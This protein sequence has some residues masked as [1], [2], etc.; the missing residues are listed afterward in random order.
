VRTLRARYPQKNP[1]TSTSRRGWRQIRWDTIAAI[2]SAIGAL[3]S[4]AVAVYTLHI[5]IYQQNI[6]RDAVKATYQSNLYSK[7]VDQYANFRVAY[8][9]VESSMMGIVLL[10]HLPS[11]GEPLS[12]EEVLD[13]QGRVKE[14]KEDMRNFLSAASRL[15]VLSP[16]SI[17][18]TMY[19]NTN[20][21]QFNFDF[22]TQ[23]LPTG[24]SSL[25]KY[26]EEIAGGHAKLDGWIEQLD[27]CFGRSLVNGVPLTEESVEKCKL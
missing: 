10:L 19:Q 18:D 25:G 20:E 13:I 15:I 22:A 3:A 12:T 11:D 26:Q 5:S 21:G 2:A 16:K 23:K 17:Q 24:A 27:A 1:T 8:R 14:T 7:Q 6:A 9:K 4:A